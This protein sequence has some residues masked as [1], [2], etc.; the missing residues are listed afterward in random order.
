MYHQQACHYKGHR[1][2]GPWQRGGWGRPGNW[3][4]WSRSI[5]VN[6]SETDSSFEL[7]LLAPGRTKED[8]KIAVKDDVLTIS[9]TE[10]AAQES[11]AHNEFRLGSFERSF[12]LNGK[13]LTDG[14]S[15]Q[16]QDG[17]LRLTLPKNPETNKPAQEVNVS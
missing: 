16:Y 10:G 7:Y 5:P 11:Y 8:F 9:Y 14:I 17:I 12:R 15:A 13:V 4:G 3:G 1:G 6:I 2:C